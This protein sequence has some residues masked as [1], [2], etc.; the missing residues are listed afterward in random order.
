MVASTPTPTTFTRTF[1]GHPYEVAKARHWV[2][3][4]LSAVIY[5]PPIPDDIV[6]T[7]VLL[8]SEAATNAIRHT[9]TGLGG[10]FTVVVHLS[11][12]LLSVHIED[13]G[14]AGEVPLH[15]KAGPFAESARGIGLVS[16]FA[17]EWGV[18]PEDA[19]V[20]FR[21]TWP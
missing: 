2:E 8:V 12:G 11:P 19:G 16:H 9:A 17:D 5:R 13:D 1:R 18:L 15:V 3:G 4:M 6:G 7:A 20:Y 21:L 10:R 14:T